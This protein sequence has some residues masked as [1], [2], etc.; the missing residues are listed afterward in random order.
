MTFFSCD[1]HDEGHLLNVKYVEKEL[2]PIYVKFLPTD[3]R[4][5]ML[6]FWDTM[7]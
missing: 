3:L 6:L 5:A 2:I 4:E 7:E 1:V